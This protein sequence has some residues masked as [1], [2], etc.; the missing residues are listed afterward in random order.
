[1][2]PFDDPAIELSLQ[3]S[4]LVKAAEC[5]PEA[6]ELI[7]SISNSV[8]EVLSGVKNPKREWLIRMNS[9]HLVEERSVGV[10]TRLS[11]GR[12]PG[13]P[14][15]NLGMLADIGLKFVPI[16]S[17]KDLHGNQFDLVILPCACANVHPS[18]LLEIFFAG[19]IPRIDILL[20]QGERFY[21]PQRI[22]LPP[23]NIFSG[24][25]QTSKM[26]QT[27]FEV[28][29]E[30]LL[31]AVDAWMN[32]AFWQGLHGATRNRLHNLV[33]ARYILF[34]DGTGAFFPE[35]GRITILPADDILKSENDLCFARLDD[36]NEGERVVLRSGNSGLLLDDASERI[37]G[38]VDHE[39]LFDKA[40]GWKEA[41]EA[42]LITLTAE[43]IS[44]SMRERGVTASSTSIAQWAGPDVLGPGSAKV[45]HQLISFL[46][47]KGKILKT[48]SELSNYANNCWEGLQELRGLHLKAGN[49]IRQD[50]FKAL[51]TRFESEPKAV[52]QLDRE[53]ISIQGDSSAQLL[54]LRVAAVDNRTAYVQLSRLG[55]IEQLE[56]NKWLG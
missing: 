19:L 16:T 39:S 52:D 9:E 18:L 48:G 46:S 15:H 24:H 54:I 29:S 2:L 37:V 30:P 11:A 33:P 1:M 41:L 3:L 5:M 6:S 25:F 32:E 42:L 28:P 34:R 44:T 35:D 8:A 20:Y 7:G 13:W 36:V 10:L 31:T 51:F 14:R 43:E 12:S 27:S 40:T 38:G 55:K 53:C 47:E 22:V 50:L 26:E 4:E 23:D 45:F 56:G 21:V 17:K 49:L